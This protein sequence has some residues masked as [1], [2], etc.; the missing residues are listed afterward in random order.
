M[1]K[2]LGCIRRADQDFNMIAPGDHVAVGV[3]GG[4]DSL[5][6]LRAL[7]L[8]RLFS[9]KDFT[10]EALLLTMGFEP[11]DTAPVEAFCAEISVP[12]TI[13]KTDIGSII[14]E[15]RNERNPCALCAKMRRGA[16][17]DIAVAHGA[18][19]L[20]LGHNREDVLETFIM[21]LFYEGRLNT[22][23]PVTYLSKSGLTVIRPMVYFP[24]MDAIGTARKYALPV[25]HNPCPANGRTARQEAKDLIRTLTKTHRNLPALMLSAL[26]NKEQYGLW[27]K[28]IVGGEK[29]LDFPC[30]PMRDMLG[31][32]EGA[33]RFHMPGHKGVLSVHDMTELTSTDDLYAPNR[34]IRDAERLAAKSCGA[35]GTIMLTGGGTAGVMAMILASVPPGGKLIL[36][37]NAHHA[38][39]SACIFGGI[40][41]VFVQDT[42]SG[43]AEHPDAAA[44]LVTRPDYFGICVNIAQIA[45]KAREHG[46]SLLVDE[47]HGAHFPWWDTPESAGRY[48]DA[49]VQ[50][51]HK[52]LPALTGAA[53]LH[54]ISPD[55]SRMRRFLRMVQTSSPPFPILESLDTARAYMDERGREALR[56]LVERL[57]ELRIKLTSLPGI[58]VLPSDDP[59]RLVISAL[60]RG[61]TGFETETYLREKRIDVEMA[62]DRCIVCI[63]TVMDRRCDLDTLYRVLS[64]LP[65]GEPLQDVPKQHPP[66]GERA[67]PL[68]EAA[69]AAHL[70]VPLE[71]STGLVCGVS[72]GLYP[73]G[74]PLLL[75]G[76]R[77]TGELIR[78]FS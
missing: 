7:S 14:F 77:I 57:R 33:V 43:I 75:P 36:S 42:L 78:Y 10:M 6:L 35:G 5:V 1:R 74:I 63:C 8:Y 2:V 71:Q 20:A 52:T 15:Q 58:R 61:L 70:T 31:A 76:E 60:G 48:A 19:K 54:S 55:T 66:P 69:L 41:A 4:K 64:R 56:L 53:W 62:D 68:R 59:T 37:R 67:L 17:N 44:V 46:V 18:N 26:H 12:L 23:H 3:S 49:W 72:A 50:S 22:F 65:F 34:G 73:P 13:K 16:L 51:A 28:K 25:I 21:S 45:E 27:D 39:I 38:A 29:W 11:F 32:A 9:K 30:G 40:N 24:E 47:A